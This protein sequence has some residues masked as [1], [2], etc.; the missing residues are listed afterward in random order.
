MAKRPSLLVTVVVA[1]VA[2]PCLAPATP[3]R[4]ES[5]RPSPRSLVHRYAAAYRPHM[6]AVLIQPI[7]ADEDDDGTVD[8]DAALDVS[9]RATPSGI[10][11][12]PTVA[13]YAHNAWPASEYLD[14]GPPRAPP[15]NIS[16]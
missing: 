7:A 9:A 1:V 3:P 8:G 10:E 4:A 12:F 14:A 13:S 6:A 2:L 16:A 11:N 5:H 15:R